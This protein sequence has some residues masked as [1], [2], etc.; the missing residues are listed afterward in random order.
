MYT[1]MC[2]QRRANVI[3]SSACRGSIEVKLSL[4]VDRSS[5]L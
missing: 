3:I 5:D 4:G 1:N 2:K